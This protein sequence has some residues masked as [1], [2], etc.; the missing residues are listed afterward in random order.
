MSFIRLCCFLKGFKPKTNLPFIF[1]SVRLHWPAITITVKICKY[2]NTLVPDVPL[3]VGRASI[4]YLM[5]K[6]K[7][8]TAF[9]LGNTCIH[10]CYLISACLTTHSESDHLDAEMRDQVLQG[11]MSHLVCGGI[12]E[13]RVE[14]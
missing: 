10:L 4:H 12:E 5:P 2:R 3:H 14:Y 8:D 7:N 11:M 9:C 1:I 13:F 6:M